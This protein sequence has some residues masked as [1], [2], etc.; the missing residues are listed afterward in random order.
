GL[1]AMELPGFAPF[2][3]AEIHN[4]FGHH[5][6]EASLL[7]WLLL[8]EKHLALTPQVFATKVTKDSSLSEFLDTYVNS[9]AS[10]ET[11]R[12][13]TST[14]ASLK[15][16]CYLLIHRCLSEVSKPP[17]LLL[18]WQFLANLSIVYAKQSSLKPL[19][20]NLWKSAGL[21]NRFLKHKISLVR[22]LE[23]GTKQHE[24]SELERTLSLVTSLLRA[25]ANYGC[26]LLLGSDFIDA[27][28][29]L[30]DSIH[31]PWKRKVVVVTYYCF[32]SP[33]DSAD[34]RFP[35]LLDHLYSLNSAK[36]QRAPLLAALCSTTP[37]VRKLRDQISGS[38]AVR[39]EKLIKQLSAF[40]GT[41]TL[42]P[43]TKKPPHRAL[44]KGKG[45]DI[46]FGHGSLDQNLHVHRVSLVAQIQDLF[47]D[48]GSAFVIRLLDEYGDDTEQVTAHVLDDSLPLHLKTSD[49]SENIP[50]SRLEPAHD[51]VPR[52]A[53]SSRRNVHDNDAFDRLTVSSSQIH[54]GPRS[55]SETADTVL[56]DRSSA[57]NKAAILSALATF[58]S[59]DD[60]RDDTYDVEDVGGT[61]DSA[62]PGSDEVDADMRDKNEEALFRAWRTNP[63][64]FERDAA[65]RRGKPRMAL[66]N[67]TEMTDEAIEGW[68][69][70]LG[71]DPR[72]MRRLEAKF[73]MFGGRQ[74]ELAKTSYRDT[75]SGTEESDHGN[76][77]IRGAPGGF[78]GRGR[79]SR[80]RGGS[81]AGPANDKETQVARQ[82]KEA[83]RGGRANHNRRNQRAKKMAK[84]G[85]SG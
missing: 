26:F 38:D 63:D 78:R 58:D 51:P 80:G 84:A 2:P 7:A 44:D 13:I 37:F 9:E 83:N 64:V 52:P 30:Y 75:G 21:Q 70:V 81:V 72:R 31:H 55:S 79:G 36:R 25:S 45:R 69:I 34:P 10:P 12:D 54:R 29:S 20:Q 59:D 35:M 66:K 50:L 47:P 82:R 19:L 74:R 71:R 8:I 27:L 39:A 40:E 43:R 41:G 15:R 4:D 49:R 5:E 68:A 53:P 16:A 18:E 24:H 17:P 85:F 3:P 42:P 73:D 33:M 65:T 60:E 11:K 22:A 28:S 77:N 6:W 14:S 23:E 48:F 57:P 67:E 1:L 62:M 32:L 61:V 76:G 56:A 46:D